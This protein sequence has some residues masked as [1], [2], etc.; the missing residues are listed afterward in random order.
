MLD[1]FAIISRNASGCI[2][3]E[4]DSSFVII[5]ASICVIFAKIPLPDCRAAVPSIFTS[6]W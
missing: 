6:S 2:P 4:G 1:P 3:G 5:F